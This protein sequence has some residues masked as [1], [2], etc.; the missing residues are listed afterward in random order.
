MYGFMLYSDEDTLLVEF[1]N[2]QSGLAALDRLSGTEC[3]IFVIESPS[4]KWIE[5]AR[6]QDHPWWRLFGSR[7]SQFTGVENQRAISNPRIAQAVEALIQNK[8]TFLVTLAD[9]QS[10][11]L[12]HLLEPD[13]ASLYDRNE[14]WD[15]VHHFGLTPKEIPCIVFFKD[16]DR[17]DIDVLCLR[18]IRTSRQATLSFR[19]FFDGPDFRRILEEA[20]RY[21]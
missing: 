13:Y 5:Y 17:G 3:A 4:R 9:D 12:R 16:L 19:D 15:V 18:D 7:N 6:K 11:T 8:D 1:M 20:R 10:V 2:R 14:I 21:A